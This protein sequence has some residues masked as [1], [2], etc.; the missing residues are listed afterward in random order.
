MVSYCHFGPEQGS[1][2]VLILIV[3]DN[4][5]LPLDAY[6]DIDFLDDVLILI[7]MDNGLLRSS[8]HIVKISMKS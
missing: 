7:V 4:G 3:M 1:E 6:R 5:L 8:S 2:G